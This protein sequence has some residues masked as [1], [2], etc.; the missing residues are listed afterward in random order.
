M[1]AVKTG[2]P[3]PSM[4]GMPAPMQPM[5][6]MRPMALPAGQ[7]P[8]PASVPP[9]PL[10]GFP[11]PPLKTPNGATGFK[12]AEAQTFWRFVRGYVGS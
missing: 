12:C 8:V 2:F 1:V 6:G 3:S 11:P 5:G 4:P 10:A 9:M 7:T